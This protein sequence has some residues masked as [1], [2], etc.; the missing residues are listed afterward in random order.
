M[1]AKGDTATNDELQQQLSHHLKIIGSVNA[2]LSVR[3]H[4]VT[5]LL[6]TLSICF[7]KGSFSAGALRQALSPLFTYIGQGDAQLR[8]FLLTELQA[9]P[10]SSTARQILL[11]YL[12]YSMPF[13]TN[14]EESELTLEASTQQVVEIMRIVLTKDQSALL[15]IIGCLSSLPLTQAGQKEVFQVALQSMEYVSEEELPTV[16]KAVLKHAKSEEDARLALEALRTELQLMESEN[17]NINNPPEHQK[18]ECMTMVGHSVLNALFDDDIGKQTAKAY[19]SLLKDLVSNHTTTKADEGDK[20]KR[21]GDEEDALVQLDLMIVLAIFQHPDYIDVCERQLDTLSR[22]NLFPFKTLC[23]LVV[24]VCETKKRGRPTSILYPRLIQPMVSMSMFLMLTPARLSKNSNYHNCATNSLQESMRKSQDFLLH[25]HH[26]ADRDVQA[27]IIHTILQLSDTLVTQWTAHP[28]LNSRKRPLRKWELLNGTEVRKNNNYESEALEWFQVLIDDTVNAT[29]RALAK[30]K[31]QS[32]TNI[33]HI[34]LGRLTKPSPGSTPWEHHCTQNVCGILTA[35]FEPATS[36][37]TSGIQASE[38][39][40]ILQKLLFTSSYSVFASSRSV[41]NSRAVR[42]LLLATELVKS[43]CI[44]H[45]DFDCIKQWVLRILLPTTRRMVD[46]EVG[47][48]G[49]NFLKALMVEKGEA[50]ADGNQTQLQLRKE[51]FQHMKMVLANTGLIQ[52][53]DYYQ[54]QS[55]QGRACSRDDDPILAYLAKPSPIFVTEPVKQQKK[56][57]DMVFC[58]A[59][60]LRNTELHRPSRW[61]ETVRW[62]FHLVQTYL[63]VGREVSLSSVKKTGNS[64]RANNKWVPHGWLQAAIEFPPL[65]LPHDIEPQNKKQQSA[66]NFAKSL[67]SVDVQGQ[68]KNEVSM[69]EIHSNLADFLV[70]CG[71]I[72]QLR[73]FFESLMRLTLSN[74]LGVSLSFAVVN[75]AYAHYQ[76]INT[77]EG[78][79]EE[80][81]ETLRLIQFQLSKIYDM[82]EKLVGLDCIL[83]AATTCLLKLV[84]RLKRDEPVRKEGSLDGGLQQEDGTATPLSP[85]RTCTEQSL[86]SSIQSS[87]SDFESVRCTQ[88]SHTILN[89]P[90]SV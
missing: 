23:D 65:I 83:K 85:G 3:R 77:D 15:P 70:G 76:S 88:R 9:V 55:Q 12:P 10:K 22:D 7:R 79:S 52:I 21:L 38:I 58:L 18:G 56:R 43:P 41:D 86:S 66:V 20:G 8:E 13:S 78:G 42:G 64:T 4:G 28:K 53:L 72:G 71:D 50:H 35:L 31:K 45:G 36:T 24:L 57:R 73:A 47:T 63:G 29:L 61:R 19:C 32:F 39:M 16:V 51:A 1:A 75:N 2:T 48:P 74:L 34:L 30:S 17:K 59:F 40:I 26:H 81:T 90:V 25:L 62:V 69:G 44:G 6:D 54:Q 49:L 11:D 60:F 46:P 67:F 5:Q 84:R 68:S 37:S 27:E 33:K 87:S 80:C 89:A 82:E 14:D